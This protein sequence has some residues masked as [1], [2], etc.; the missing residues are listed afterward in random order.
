VEAMHP[1]AVVISPGP[2]VPSAAGISVPLIRA[3]TGKVP[4]LGVCL[5]HQALG[6]A[7]GGHVVRADRIMHGKSSPIEHTGTGLFAGLPSPFPAMRYHSLV[8]E[9]STLPRELEITAWSADRPAGNEIM[10]LEHREHPVFGVQFHPESVGTEVGRT[11]L[12]NFVALIPRE[13]AARGRVVTL[14]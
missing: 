13:T 9:P 12:S 5:G 4:I 1:A 3:L 8:V 6:E 2:G 11:L 7:F 10:G 14:P